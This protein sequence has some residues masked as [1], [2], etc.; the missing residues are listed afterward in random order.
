MHL[1]EDADVV[2][3]LALEVKTGPLVQCRPCLYLS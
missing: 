1:H 3:M 2:F